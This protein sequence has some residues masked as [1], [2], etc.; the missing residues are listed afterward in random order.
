[1]GKPWWKSKT[2]WTNLTAI[3]TGI[4]AIVTG[5]VGLA[6]GLPPVIIA[7]VNIALRAI[8]KEPIRK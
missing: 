3:V 7:A 4:G 1:M 8:T 2:V 6:T 5:Q